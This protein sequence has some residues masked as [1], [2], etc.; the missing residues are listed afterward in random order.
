MCE[1]V[2]DR[3]ACRG[4]YLCNQV[5]QSVSQKVNVC[6]SDD[7]MNSVTTVYQSSKTVKN[8]QTAKMTIGVPIVTCLHRVRP[9]HKAHNC[10]IVGTQQRSFHRSYDYQ[11]LCRAVA[12]KHAEIEQLDRQIAFLRYRIQELL[13]NFYKKPGCWPM[14]LIFMLC[15]CGVFFNKYRITV[16]NRISKIQVFLAPSLCEKRHFTR[17]NS[18]V[19]GRPG[20]A[21]CH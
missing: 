15:I 21:L 9:I 13:H 2:I 12:A 10:G 5:H 6:A 8:S 17:H 7:H 4:P 1:R 20:D 11:F 16:S 14:H 18:A 19:V 3:L